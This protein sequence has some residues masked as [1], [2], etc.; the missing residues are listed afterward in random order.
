VRWRSPVPSTWVCSQ[1]EGGR[2]PRNKGE[3]PPVVRDVW[4]APETIDIWGVLVTEP[5][6]PLKTF[7][8]VEEPN[9]TS[10]YH[11]VDG[12]SITTFGHYAYP[13]VA[14]EIADLGQPIGA[15]HGELLVVVDKPH[16]RGQWPS[17][18]SEHCQDYYVLVGQVSLDRRIVEGLICHDR[19]V[20]PP[21]RSPPSGTVTFLFTDIEGSTRLW[22]QSPREMRVSSSSR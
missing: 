22:E 12:T 8:A 19:T 2:H 21:P 3:H 18:G 20:S 9:L 7:I 11:T 17:A 14:F 16:R 10:E 5:A 15:H 1:S 6:A 13:G 4:T